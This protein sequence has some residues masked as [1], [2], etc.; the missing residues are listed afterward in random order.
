[1]LKKNQMH[2][3]LLID[4]GF[5]EL[6]VVY[7][8]HTFRRAGLSIK[9]VSLGNKLVYSQHGVAIKADHCLVDE[10]VRP[11]DATMLI[12]PARGYNGESLRRDARVKSLIQSVTTDNGLVAVTDEASPLA[13]DLGEWLPQVTCQPQSGQG[14]IEFVNGLADRI[15]LGTL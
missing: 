13:K 14:L 5:D 3:F 15:G 8:L 7:L 4:D 2:S 11:N 10:P 9:S 12:L 1:M 6:E